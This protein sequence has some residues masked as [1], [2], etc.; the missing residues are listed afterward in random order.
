MMIGGCLADAPSCSAN[1]SSNNRRKTSHYTIYIGPTESAGASQKHA[2]REG[3]RVSHSTAAHR[4][5]TSSGRGRTD[6]RSCRLKEMMTATIHMP[7]RGGGGGRGEWGNQHTPAQR[8]GGRV[9]R[10]V[11]E[12]CN[13]KGL[14]HSQAR[15]RR[16]DGNTEPDQIRECKVHWASRSS[17]S[18]SR[19]ERER[20]SP[21]TRRPRGRRIGLNPLRMWEGRLSRQNTTKYYTLSHLLRWLGSSPRPPRSPAPPTQRQPFSLPCLRRRPFRPGRPPRRT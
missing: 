21:V 8:K 19:C 11:I 1:V 7:K 2:R 13:K 18:F 14:G 15:D 10:R 4:L 6:E 3:E 5:P 9:R 20:D 12:A 16:G 17:V